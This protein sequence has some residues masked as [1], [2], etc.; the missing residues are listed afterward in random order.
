MTAD[1]QATYVSAIGLAMDKGLYQKFVYIHQEQMS[2]REAHGTCVFLFWHRKYLLGFENMLRSLG[3]RYKC[4]TLPYWDYVQHYST[5]QKTRNC[6]SIESCSPVTKALGGSTQGSRS[7]K[8]LFGYTFSSFTCVT[9]EPANHMCTTAGASASQCDHCVPR[10]NW[11][12]KQ[13]ITDMSIDSVRSSVFSGSTI[14]SV[15]NAIEQTPHNILHGTLDGALSNVYVSPSDP[16]FFIHHNTIDLLHTIYYHCRVEP[17]GLTPAQQQTDTQSFQGCRT[18]NGVNVGPTSSLTMR[19][20]DVTNKVDVS[21]D[22][23]VGKFFQGL[24]TQYYQLTDV[25]SL[26]YSYAF[27]GLL[28][29]MYDKCDGSKMESF[30]PTDSGLDID[31]IVQPIT[32]DEN[33][34]SIAMRD[35]VLELASTIGL[36]QE[37]AYHELRK[38]TLLM[39]EQCLPGSVADF[40]PDFKA[41][42][43]INTTA[44]A[45]ALLQA[46]QS[47][48]D[49]IVIPGWDAVLMQFYNCSTTQ[50]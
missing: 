10:G 42:W 41:M 6:N 1:E 2:N 38:M 8:A 24:P 23:V 46:I 50:A 44:P 21:K 3:D 4:L 18:G 43:H 33:K 45:F 16:M 12:N 31:H 5:M 9:A 49:P 27:K 26:G 30:A 34:V 14:A 39:H 15:S 47:G 37:Q 35:R 29:D 17:R 28:G 13:M 7:S 48:A 22:P 36:T 40:T 20:G 19:A 32:L 11:A 25:R